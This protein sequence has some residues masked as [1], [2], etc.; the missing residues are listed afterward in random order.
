MTI[1]RLDHSPSADQA[2]GLV[3]QQMAAIESYGRWIEQLQAAT[4]QRMDARSVEPLPIPASAHAQMDWSSPEHMESPRGKAL[5]YAYEAYVDLTGRLA[6]V[7]ARVPMADEV[8]A[9]SHAEL[10]LDEIRTRLDGA[11]N[12]FDR[13]RS[14]KLPRGRAAQRTADEI[15]Q[16]WASVLGLIHAWD[17]ISFQNMFESHSSLAEARAN[18]IAVEHESRVADAANQADASGQVLKSQSSALLD[19]LTG[20]TVPACVRNLFTVLAP[21]GGV[22]A[23]FAWMP[24]EHGALLVCAAGNAVDDVAT[25]AVHDLLVTVEGEARIVL[26]DTVGA[27]GLASSLR[28]LSN[29]MSI[30]FATSRSAANA[31]LQR[32][33]EG[34]GDRDLHDPYTLIIAFLEA[35]PDREI[36]ELIRRVS[37]DSRSGRTALLCLSQADLASSLVNS[38]G[39][40]LFAGF[41]GSRGYLRIESATVPAVVTA[42]SSSISETAL[43]NLAEINVQTDASDRTRSSVDQLIEGYGR[44]SSLDALRIAVG[45]D[46]SGEVVSLDFG[47]GTQQ[48]ALIVGQ[49]GSGKST[50]LHTII[51]SS[52]ATFGSDEVHHYLI[53]LKEGVEFK[54]YAR[55]DAVLPSARVVAVQGQVAFALSVLRGLEAELKRRGVIFREATDA[56]GIPIPNITTYRNATGRSMPRIL[57]AID[58]FQTLFDGDFELGDEAAELLSRLVRQG[59]SAGIHLVLATQTIRDA[60]RLR[61]LIDQMA[62][63]LVLKS[64]DTDRDTMVEGGAS[65]TLDDP[66]V[67]ILN[68]E[69]GAPRSNRR[70]WVAYAS[71]QEQIALID[72][73]RDRDTKVEHRIFDGTARPI[74]PKRVPVKG[75]IPVVPLGE[76]FSL[77]QEVSVRLPPQP[78]A[79]VAIVGPDE[80]LT[81]DVIRVY[82]DAVKALD[83]RVVLFDT[84]RFDD[85]GDR[86]GLASDPALMESVETP[87]R[88]D[89]EKTLTQLCES[90]DTRE[91]GDA[92]VLLVFECLHRIR[93]LHPSDSFMSDP[94]S[95]A[96]K[97]ETVLRLGPEVGIHAVASVDSWR[98]LG[99]ST[100]RAGA[101]E[102]ST[103]I[104]QHLSRDES[105]NVL[106]FDGAAR[107]GDDA[108]LLVNKDEDRSFAFRPYRAR[109]S[110]R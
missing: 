60:S 28:P 105:I 68:H 46:A 5:Q 108:C 78:G 94:D 84:P 34:L 58:E 41:D 76:P 98:R 83:G 73:L 37:L 77:D 90:L 66:G 63:R 64:S 79:N 40:F 52:A 75:R 45:R 6:A 3:R 43:A 71:A 29:Q 80:S 87:G 85:V 67:A 93:D 57:L 101:K 17:G 65:L 27:L 61:P 47:V 7:G 22:L 56:T 33:L 16:T 59:R 21:S 26:I 23:P 51:L 10:R 15:V 69:S 38:G 100:T 44:Q 104:T 95:L 13:M 32:H 20:S 48:H 55:T 70:F 39:A 74:A 50:L 89:F 19:A 86:R 91:P 106:G 1:E 4:L 36:L 62:I 88:R 18:Q 81:V 8:Q 99:E 42:P 54:L 92:P 103:V 31:V 11:L 82:V 35:E 107:L 9:D 14:A 96:G 102:F 53:D 12:M 2:R 25:H 110:G 49:V 30:E 24:S 97:V 109:P 72:R